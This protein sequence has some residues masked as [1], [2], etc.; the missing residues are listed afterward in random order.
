MIGGLVL[1]ALALLFLGLAGKAAASPDITWAEFAPGL[2]GYAVEGKAQLADA[3]PFIDRNGRLLVPLRFLARALGVEDRN[4][5]WDARARTV[6]LGP[7]GSPAVEFTVGSARYR[8]LSQN[9]RPEARAMDT[10]PVLKGGRVYLPARYLAEALGWGVWW[11]EKERK[12]TLVKWEPELTSSF[13]ERLS[14]PFYWVAYNPTAYDPESGVWPDEASIR[15][16]LALLRRAGF[17]GVITYGLNPALAEIPRLAKEAGFEAVIAGIWDIKNSEELSAAKK[18]AAYADA[19]C[20]GHEGLVFGRY[21]LAELIKAMRE[22]RALTGRPVATSEPV[23]LYFRQSALLRLGDFL[24]PVVHPYW[25]GIKA[26][27]AAARFT[28][29]T[30]SR[31]AELSG[32]AVLCK[33][34]GLPSA[35][36]EGLS[37]EVQLE[38]YRRLSSTGTAFA[39]FEAFDQAWKVSRPWV[40]RSPVETHWGLFDAQ[41][42]PKAAGRWLLERAGEGLRPSETKSATPFVAIATLKSGQKVPWQTAV[43]GGWSG[44]PDARVYLLVWP[45]DPRYGVDGPWWVQATETRPDGSWRSLAFFGED[46]KAHPEHSGVRFRVVAVLTDRVL[47]PG[48][49]LPA[50]PPHLAASET[51]EV[52]RE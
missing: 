31:L 11:D 40:E 49:T 9:A 36:A 44:P 12:V 47:A 14:E 8:I 37:E 29:D 20:V 16:D 41:R 46:P 28:A 19:Y 2:A 26:P 4:V 38:F 50:L 25:A 24:L 13:Q 3:A 6:T 45:V 22:L 23:H 52:V 43:G 7:P 32:R 48:A 27:E 15:E 35:G 1:A 21:R 51:V 30:W 18:A 39:W 17:K 33:E 5:R 42:R 34:T 10:A